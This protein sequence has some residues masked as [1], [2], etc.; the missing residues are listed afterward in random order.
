MSQKDTPG[1]HFPPPFMFFLTGWAGWWLGHKMG[2]LV[3][4]SSDWL[5]LLGV[6]L[7]VAGFALGAWAL[8]PFLFHKTSPLPWEADDKLLVTGPYRFSRNPMYAGMALL[9]AGVGIGLGSGMV[10]LLLLP[11]ILIINRFVIAGEE[12]YLLRTFGE[13][14]RTFHSKV[15]R[16]L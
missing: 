4:G 1:V 9:Y 13:E 11:L 5:D 16:W 7:I 14:Y 3:F 10:I 15:R 12:A 6:V 2:W 8:L